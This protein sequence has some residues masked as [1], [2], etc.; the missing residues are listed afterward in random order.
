[1]LVRVVE[2]VLQSRLLDRTVVATTTN[3]EDD[4]VEELCNSRGYAVFRGASEDV[5][6][7]YYQAAQVYDAETVVRITAD[8][9]LIDP[10]IIDQTITEFKKRKVDFAANRLPPPWQRTFPEGLDVEVC[11]FDA[12]AKAW[13]EAKHSYHREHVMP[14]LY[15]SEG[16]FRIF[17]L[18]HDPDYGEYRLSVDV[19]EDLQLVREIYRRLSSN[20]NFSWYDVI[21]LLEDNPD[22]VDINSS[23][24]QKNLW[25]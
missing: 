14:Y 12:L 7:R 19:V 3:P 8:C 16:R 23:V 20:D 10:D 5:L 22:L 11:R 24:V 21:E 9:P 4:P 25:Q 2:R 1:M 6:D 15:E 18:Q 13:R 17:V